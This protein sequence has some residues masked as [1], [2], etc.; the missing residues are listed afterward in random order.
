MSTWLSASPDAVGF[1]GSDRYNKLPP[2]IKEAIGFCPLDDFGWRFALATTGNKASVLTRKLL[3]PQP[4]KI[5]TSYP[6]EAAQEIEKLAG[7]GGPIVDV[8]ELGGSVEAAP[9]VFPEVDGIFDLVDTGN[10][11]RDNGLQIVAGN[12][13]MIALGG[14]W[15][16]DA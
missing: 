6:A 12:L 3:C 15:R 7:P 13:G 4:V 16:K 5:A 11:I 1:M 10:T 2:N 9:I 8:M 14:V